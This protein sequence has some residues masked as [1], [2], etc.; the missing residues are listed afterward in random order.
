MK[1]QILMLR[2]TR[3][4]GKQSCLCH[5]CRATRSDMKTTDCVNMYVDLKGHTLTTEV[6]VP[7]RKVWLKVSCFGRIFYAW[8]NKRGHSSVIPASDK[9]T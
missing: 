5:G 4:D 3:P 7:C 2:I 6:K 8:Q 9:N 1:R